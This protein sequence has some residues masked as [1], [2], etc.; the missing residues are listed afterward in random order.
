MPTLLP[1]QEEG[2][3]WLAGGDRRALHD[4]PRAGKCPQT[5]VAADDI[6]AERVVVITKAIARVGWLREF[7]KWSPYVRKDLYVQS[8][9][10][11]ATRMDVR[12][13]IMALAPDVLVLDE[14][15]YCKNLE[16][17]RT[18]FVFGKVFQGG[19]IAAAERVWALSA[20]PIPNHVGEYFAPL[21]GLVPHLLPAEAR[22]YEGFLNRYAGTWQLDKW[23][24]PRVHGVNRE[25]MAEL[26][27]IIAKFA[28]GRKE[29]DPRIAM[30]LPTFVI[31]DL[32]IER[33]GAR[34]HELEALEAEIQRRQDD[35]D[36]RGLPAPDSPLSRLR[37]L[38]G[39]AKAGPV[40]HLVAEELSDGEYDKI[41][42]FA[43][44]QETIGALSMILSRFNPLVVTGAT[45]EVERNRAMDLFRSDRAHRVFIGQIST[46]QEAISLA[47][48]R[49]CV[50]VERDWV[51]GNNYQATRRLQLL[52]QTHRIF[53]RFAG[54]AD[55]LDE[56]M[57][58]SAARKMRDISLLDT[59]LKEIA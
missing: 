5:I 10:M 31:Q 38:T 49:H 13:E 53:I 35:A 8:Y 41:V 16:A 25:H 15:H 43:W 7:A 33:D 14:Y 20:T 9:D 36:E 6:G 3:A 4:F 47:A 22:T 48:A 44:H 37:R 21:R 39:R 59:T 32:V 54:L 46:C 19:L 45:T 57:A 51:P 42:L 34:D 50:F 56:G 27:G 30:Q 26:R 11:V 40:A 55:S 1:Y 58:R 18:K 12:A 23:R 2:A 29:S 17:K 28:I 24:K 52:G